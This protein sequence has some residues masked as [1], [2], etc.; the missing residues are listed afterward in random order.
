MGM[1]CKCG[2]KFNVVYNDTDMDFELH[3]NT[4]LVSWV[5]SRYTEDSRWIAEYLMKD[6]A[7]EM[8]FW[9]RCET[10]W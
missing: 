2:A 10:P 3:H 8:R 5:S 7:N 6:A 1:H 4:D 9:T